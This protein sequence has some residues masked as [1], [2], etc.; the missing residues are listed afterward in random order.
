MQESWLGRISLWWFCYSVH[1]EL[2]PG[3]INLSNG[4]R[5]CGMSAWPQ[6]VAAGFGQ[7]MLPTAGLI[8]PAWSSTELWEG[9]TGQ[10]LI[11]SA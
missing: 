4:R 6:E 1:T 11:Y 5:G 8:A 10:L 7:I 3:F 9:G 2:S